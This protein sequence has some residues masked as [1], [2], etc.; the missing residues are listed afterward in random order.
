MAVKVQDLQPGAAV[1]VNDDGFL[2]LK[3]ERDILA[4]GDTLVKATLKKL[5]TGMPTYFV[6]KHDAEVDQMSL[7][8]KE[9]T[10]GLDNGD[11][12]TFIDD[13]DF[14]RYEVP[15]EDLQGARRFI[16]GGMEDLCTLNFYN[17]TFVSLELPEVVFRKVASTKDLS[18]TS[19]TTGYAK[20]AS[21]TSISI[22]DEVKA[23]QYIDINTKTGLCLGI[24][25]E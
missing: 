24:S 18:S 3:V 23:E 4:K 11:S 21:G 14:T 17:K 1:R 6:W 8:K 2:V 12:Y 13:T 15:A 16:E 19:G 9:A 5:E 25:K 22:P 20:L 10:F 7:D